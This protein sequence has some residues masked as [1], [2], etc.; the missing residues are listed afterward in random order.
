MYNIVVD[1]LGGDNGSSPI[2]KAIKD[3]LKE[4]P[5]IHIIAVGN[6][7]ELSELKDL[8]EIVHAPDIV[9]MEAGPLEVMRM[10]NSS[11]Y[12]A[13]KL[14]KDRNADAV[15]SAGSTGGFLS[16]ATLILKTAPGVKR[17]ALVS[18]F[19]TKIKGK[20]VTILD[21]GA[22]NENSPEELVQF[23]AMGSIYA[24]SV[25][26]IENPSIYLLSNGTEDGKG[27]PVSKAAFKLLKDN[28]N[29]K[30]NMEARNALSG[31]ADV[32]VCDG[33]TGNIFLKGCEGIA[34]MMS[35]MIKDAFKRNLWSKIGYLHV[36][37]GI[38]EMTETMDYKSTGGAMLLGINGV[39]IKA[40]G[41][42]DD[43]S[44][45]CALNVAKKMVES[46]VCQNISERLK[47]E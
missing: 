37:K 33:F 5:D 30:G 13:N 20:K 18:P 31:E 21:I 45:H 8:C 26:N 4:N 34:K 46:K 7:N 36:R 25:F 41:N 35:G 16:C 39:V 14:M 23:A 6:E 40:H 47:N 10:K 38:K 29:F 44:F 42:S 43:Y 19:P 22:N 28:P 1:T 3:F 9:P 11:L 24:N 32:I 27:S 17:A 2:I 12:V 15:I